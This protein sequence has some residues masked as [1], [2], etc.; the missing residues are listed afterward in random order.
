MIRLQFILILSTLIW[1][2]F[3]HF[4]QSH[5]SFSIFQF[6]KHCFDELNNV[7]WNCTD[8]LKKTELNYVK[9]NHLSLSLSL[10]T[11]HPVAN[12]S[13]FVFLPYSLSCLLFLL[14]SFSS[15]L[16]LHLISFL[17]YQPFP[18]P[19]PQKFLTATWPSRPN[20]LSQITRIPILWA[21]K[22]ILLL[23]LAN[24]GEGFV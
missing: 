23:V 21:T 4:V 3:N 1:F 7:N 12:L 5:F 6:L 19:T 17:P 2:Q 14:S 8:E 22:Q 15:R 9:L 11:C 13:V 24:K 18:N 16:F 10:Y 20:L